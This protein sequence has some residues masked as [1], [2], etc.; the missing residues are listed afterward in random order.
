M[1]LSNPDMILWAL[2]AIP[3]VLLFLLKARV[4][5]VPVS[6]GLFWRQIFE[7]KQSRSLW[8]SLRYLLS[9]L[10][11]LLLPGLSAFVL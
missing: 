11:Q 3:V 8:R 4:R 10:A 9:L 7:Q 6:T 2:L 1:N 5:R